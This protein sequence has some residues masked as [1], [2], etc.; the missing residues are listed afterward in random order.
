MLMQSDDASLIDAG[1]SLLLV[2]DFQQRLMPAIHEGAAMLGNAVILAQAAKVL[3][4]PALATEQYPQGLG[5]S[6]P[7]V[8]ALCPHSIEKTT[9]GANAT[10]AFGTALARLSPCERPTLIVCGCETH[11]C[12]LQTV[13]QLKAEGV[14][15]RVVVDAVGSRSALS[16][17]IALRRMEA[18]GIA[19]VTTEMVL[20]E[21]LRDA[22][23]PQF[24]S[25][26]KLIK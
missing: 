7:E 2:I 23:H 4:I 22:N 12:V 6:A 26:L 15:V 5:H 25:L 20:F 24:R 16:K 9:F 3:E 17:E 13:L 21:W 19:L 1:R 8:I 10:P 11:V 14:D 18:A